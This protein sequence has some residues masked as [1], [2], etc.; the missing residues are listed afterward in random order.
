MTGS[1]LN[2]VDKPKKP[3]GTPLIV[4]GILL[5]LAGAAL[6]VLMMPAL[7]A[8]AALGLL[9]CIIGATGKSSYKKK[10]QAYEAYQLANSQRQEA[11][12]K[13][14]EIQAQLTREQADI[15]SLEQELS[16]HQSAIDSDVGEVSAW[17]TR[18]NQSG[19]EA[20]ETVIVQIMDH[21]L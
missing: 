4:I 9:L 13:K 12:Q 11:N 3:A 16:E 18:W 5:I 2:V 14:A 15:A 1:R 10:V 6:G 19:G 7:A 21:A 20:S 17:V 8:V